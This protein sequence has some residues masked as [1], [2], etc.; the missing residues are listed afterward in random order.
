MKEDFTNIFTFPNGDKVRV[1]ESYKGEYMKFLIKRIYKDRSLRDFDYDDERFDNYQTP[2]TIETAII[3]HNGE[4]V[5][6]EDTYIALKCLD[7]ENTPKHA[8]GN[9]QKPNVEIGFHIDQHWTRTIQTKIPLHS[10]QSNYRFQDQ[11]LDQVCLEL[12]EGKHYSKI[13]KR[14]HYDIEFY[15]ENGDSKYFEVSKERL[16]NY[17]DYVLF[18]P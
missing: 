7:W 9:G 2:K 11:V 18:L 13:T 8:L 14:G 4:M 10:V 16:K 15:S 6:V 3:N 1:R 17:I 5:E 12:S